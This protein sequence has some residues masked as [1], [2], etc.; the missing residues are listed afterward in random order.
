MAVRMRSMLVFATD[1]LLDWVG[2]STVQIVQQS[3]LQIVWLIVR[4]QTGT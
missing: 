2:N 1:S 3:A 4:V